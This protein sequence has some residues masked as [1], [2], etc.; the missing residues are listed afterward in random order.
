MGSSYE[1]W[2][3]NLNGGYATLFAT[4]EV[5]SDADLN[6]LI[7]N[8]DENNILNE[9]WD[10]VIDKRNTL[11]SYTAKCCRPKDGPLKYLSVTVFEDCSTEILGDFYMDN[12]YRM[13]WDKTLVEHKQLQVDTSTGTEFVPGRNACEI[14]MFHQE[15]AGLNVEMAKLAFSK[16]IWSYVCKMDNA[17][18]KYSMNSHPQ[19]I[20]TV[21]AVTLIQKVPVGLEAINRMNSPASPTA[22]IHGLY[23][24]EAKEKKL[25]RRPS[26]KVVV[27]GLLLLGG[28]IC[29]SRGHSAL[30]AKVAIAYILTKLHKRSAS[31]QSGQVS[32]LNV[33]YTSLN[34]PQQ[35]KGWKSSGGDPCGDSWKGIKCSGSSVT[36]IRLSG[37]GVSGSLGYQ[38]GNLKS[39]S[40]LSSNN[41]N[42]NI[43]YQLPPKLRQLD[44]S[45]N[46]LTGNLPYSISQMTDLKSLKLGRRMEANNVGQ[47]QPIHR[48]VF[49][50][51]QYQRV[52]ALTEA[53]LLSLATVHLEGDAVPWYQCLEH[54]MGQMTWEQFKRAL[55]TRFGSLEEA[56]ADADAAK[57]AELE[58]ESKDALPKMEISLKAFTGLSPQNT[59][60]FYLLPVS[61]CDI[62]FGAEWLQSLGVILWDFSKLT[63]Q[64]SWKGH[65]VQLTGNGSSPT[66]LANHSE[67]KRLLLQEKQGV[68]IQ[69]MALTGEDTKVS[70]PPIVSKILDTYSEVF[71]EPKGLPPQRSLDHHIPYLQN[72]QLTGSIN[73]LAALP[74]NDLSAVNYT[75]LTWNVENN[76]FTG[77]VP[78]SLK[79]ISKTG[80]NSWSSK[81]APPPPP[82]TRPIAKRGKSSS[83]NKKSSVNGIIIGASVLGALA[84]I[85][86][87]IG[88]FSKRRRSSPSSNFLDEERSCERREFTPLASQELSKDLRS[89]RKDYKESNSLN[90]N[91]SVDIKPFQRSTSIG[92]KDPLTDRVK[93]FH[94]NE[95]ANRLK[96]QRSTSTPAISYSLTELQTATANFATGR[97][98]GEGTIGRVYRA[99]YPDG[100]VLTVKKIDSS[101]FR[102]DNAENFSE[103]VA[104]ISRIRHTNIAELVGYCAEQGH[105]ILIYDY[106]R[107]GSIHDF[108]HM[109]DDFSKPLTWNTRIR[110]ALGTGRAVEYLHEGCSPSLIHKNIKS[111]NILLDLELNP[112]LSDYGLANFHQRTSQN[113]G[114]GYNAPECTKPSAYTLKSDVYS[115]GVVMLE[116]LTGRMPFDSKRPKP[117]QC[118]VRWA[119]PQLHDID[120]LAKMVD[121]ALRGLYPPKSLSRFADVIALCVQPEPEFRPPMSEVVEALVRL[122]QRST[123][124]MRDDLAASRRTEDSDY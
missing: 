13:Q 108:L 25:S 114:V 60:H 29:L 66:V 21:S 53:E 27:K 10:N 67:F 113:L 17:L 75:K 11:F 43:P 52:T 48:W 16:G 77:W 78:D 82:G 28:A 83:N 62:V 110:I 2:L 70:L 109:S 37:I 3:Q 97:L 93:S 124:N 23:T 94:D 32:A 47:P 38:L 51:E 88:I 106:Y 112:H 68:F 57:D 120:A 22:T 111:S 50:S 1:F 45:K 40:D 54:S 123:M 26:K 74:L 84:V 44:L 46:S 14:K 30:G 116:L 4:S 63:M 64:F 36:E 118:L 31:S 101:L 85:A 96:S 80:G 59:M 56:Y 58:N 95:F 18:R 99:K 8:L 5:V 90:S 20:A 119:A 86:I 71:S 35:L 117:E 9:H 89:E 107:N 102:G 115:F 19:T 92:L 91:A 69:L 105:N 33:L 72:N 61:G 24:G 98:L 79:D 73:V 87:V 15:D 34:S 65:N 12:D 121:P 39:H 103:I 7:Q 81:A 104:N 55:Q 6:F 41:I 49:R 100:K 122:V 76:Q 42:N